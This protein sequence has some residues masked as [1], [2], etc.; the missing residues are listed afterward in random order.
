MSLRLLV[1]VLLLIINGT[2]VGALGQL[3]DPAEVVNETAGKIVTEISVREAEFRENPE[4]LKEIIRRDLLPVFDI[5]YSA[6][7]ILGRAGRGATSQQLEAF[8]VAMS[9]LLIDRYATGLLEYR[10][11]SQLQVMPTRG[12][13]NERLT[14]VRTRVRLNSGKYAPVDYA[15]R[16]TDEGW[17]AFDVIIEGISYVT[18][19]RNQIMPEVQQT[20]LDAVIARLSSGELEFTE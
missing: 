4:L 2:P 10:S 15:F 20:G 5:D 17:K 1:P 16:M 13:I 19:Y 3:S 14:R 12:K 6:R 18:T 11:Q 8:S 7:L 9:E